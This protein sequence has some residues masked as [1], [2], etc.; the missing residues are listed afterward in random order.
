MSRPAPLPAGAT[1]AG[2]VV[3]RRLHQTVGSVVYEVTDPAIGATFVLKE[4]LPE[5][6]VRRG[7]D[8]SVAPVDDAARQAFEAG[9]A[10]FGAEARLAAG[11]SHPGLARVLRLVEANGTAYQLMPLYDGRP[12]AE[13]LGPDSPRERAKAVVLGLM[14]AV[15][16]LH[17]HGVIHQDIKPGNVL[18]GPDDEVLLL[19]FGAAG[20]RDGRRLGS[21]GHAAPEQSDPDATVGP[22]T[23]VYGLAA[24]LYRCFTG[25][26]PPPA[27]QR[28]RAIDAGESDPLTP[29]RDRLPVNAWGGLADAIDHGLQLDPAER[30]SDIGQWRRSFEGLDWRLGAATTDARGDAEAEGRDWLPRALLGV[31][32]LSLVGIALFLLSGREARLPELG[33]EP[34]A[35]TEPADVAPSGDRAAS[36]EE[37]AQWRAALEADT[38]L[39][40]RRFLET[41]PD[42]VFRE[43]VRLQIEVLDERAWQALSAEDSKAAYQRYLEQFPGG[44]HE[45]AALRAIERIDA[46]EALAER[47]RLARRK[48][49]DDAWAAARETGT[50]AA[51]DAYIDAW[52]AGESV[53]TARELRR[54][55]LDRANDDRAWDTAARI[56]TREAFRSY[57]DAFPE[58]EHVTD[59][60]AAIDRL[61]LSPG[62]TFRDCPVCPQMTVVPSGS[63]QQGAAEEDDDAPER[64]RPRRTVSIDRPFAAG[65]FE[66]TMAE[67]DACAAAGGCTETPPDNGWG[68]GDRPVM[69]VSWNDAQQ[70]VHWLNEKTGE[71]YR[72]P[73]ESEWEYMARAGVDGDWH[74]GDPAEACGFGNVAGAETDFQWR[75]DACEDTMALGTLPA[76][77]LRPND[78]GLFDVIGNVAEWT[79]DCMNLSYLDA[80]TDGSAWTR[81]ICASHM[82]RGGSWVTGTR[83]I[84]LSARF[85]LRNGDRNDFTGFRVVRELKD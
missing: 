38:L 74:F 53:G 14:G 54:Q 22:A 28:R 25:D 44:L 72:L 52:P 79:A 24:T 19:D 11:L 46:T 2:L 30:P 27:D 5:G 18:L 12:L 84:R 31:V 55:I 69:M 67:W 70:Y 8:Q 51:L 78:F 71:A 64:E 80:P 75:H 59:A 23:D 47:E 37:R 34:P 62:K 82:A 50:V 45:A 17:E 48:A 1:V 85:N 13:A 3:N 6:L 56:D 39:G 83:D 32:L 43:Q 29:A 81:G 66:V 68:R 42:S 60:L 20:A 65:V 41:W 16:A 7:N 33:G 61:T 35:R 57:L 10:D 40:Y 73:S 63:F 49:D 9:L 21:P 15:A 4:F 58:G 77:S 26:T 76:G 36:A